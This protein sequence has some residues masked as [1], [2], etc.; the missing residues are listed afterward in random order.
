MNNLEKYPETY[1][2]FLDYCYKPA[3]V[4]VTNMLQ[5]FL[6]QEGFEFNINRSIFNVHRLENEVV[7]FATFKMRFKSTGS[8]IEEL[9][10]MN[11]IDEY[12]Y[13]LPNLYEACFEILEY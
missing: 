9:K 3:N 5:S 4:N 1:S 13:E 11:S 6:E 8:K 12:F 2:K 10:V 7:H